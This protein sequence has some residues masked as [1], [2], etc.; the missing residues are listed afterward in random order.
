MCLFYCQLI[1]CDLTTVGSAVN[2]SE[3]ESGRVLLPT[4]WTD[5]LFHE[6]E[7][8]QEQQEEEERTSH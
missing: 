8:Q 4:R 2:S 5:P 7:E 1:S 6:E 3:Q